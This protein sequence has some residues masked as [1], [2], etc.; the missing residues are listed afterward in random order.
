[1]SL[2]AR[3]VIKIHAAPEDIWAV[4]TEPEYII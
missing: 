3:D 4:L 2:V 1:M